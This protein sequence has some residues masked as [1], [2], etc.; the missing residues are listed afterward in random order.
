M[1][2]SGLIRLVAVHELSDARRFANGIP[3][4]IV[5]RE[6]F[7]TLH[8]DSVVVSGDVRAHTG[9]LCMWRRRPN[10]RQMRSRGC[11]QQSRLRFRGLGGEEESDDSD[12]GTVLLWGRGKRQIDGGLEK[13]REGHGRGDKA[14]FL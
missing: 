7:D 14:L 13:T 11:P 10:P 6:Q 1:V 3:H 5:Q 2:V 8:K 9:R 12:D 4:A